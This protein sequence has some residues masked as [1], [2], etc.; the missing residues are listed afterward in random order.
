MAN[1]I[2]EKHAVCPL[3]A[4]HKGHRLLRSRPERDERGCD[5]VKEAD[6]AI[7]VCNR[8]IYWLLLKVS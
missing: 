3:R 8:K 2:T 4:T 1:T 6:K 7:V 5:F